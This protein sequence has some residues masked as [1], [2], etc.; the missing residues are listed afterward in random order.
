MNRASTTIDFN[1]DIREEHQSLESRYEIIKTLGSGAFGQVYKVRNKTATHNP[2]R[3]LKEIP[4]ATSSDKNTKL[5][6]IIQE[7]TSLVQLQCSSDINNNNDFFQECSIVEVYDYFSMD[8]QM[9]FYIEMEYISGGNLNS[10][11]QNLIDHKSEKQALQRI[12]HNFITLISTLQNVHAHCILHR[13][14]KPENILY[15]A[16]HDQ[17]VLGDF[18]SSCSQENCFGVT[19]T[20]LF[21][22]PI[23]LFKTRTVDEASDIYSLGVCFYELITQ[24]KYLSH[25]IDEQQYNQHYLEAIKQLQQVQN[26][27]FRAR[28]DAIENILD[29]T[30]A[31]FDGNIIIPVPQIENQILVMIEAVIKMIDPFN[32]KNRPSLDSILFYLTSNNLDNIINDSINNSN[33]MHIDIQPIK[34]Y[35]CPNLQE[36]LRNVEMNHKLLLQLQALIVQ[37]IKNNT[38]PLSDK[39]LFIRE[40][41]KLMK[42]NKSIN[43]YK[44]LLILLQ[45]HQ[46]QLWQQYKHLILV[47]SING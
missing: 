20:T 18:G 26:R 46:D 24:E 17:L 6:N 44:I 45:Q 22:D 12:L 40:L 27:V 14:I 34:I 33:T 41:K 42:L 13:D 23:A 1:L 31:P 3:A 25:F 30:D 21:I 29:Y 28:Q 2:I 39:T 15:D 37:L 10:F 32:I 43:Q 36:P 9:V 8:Q 4:I 11:R 47:N 7:I 5:L 38:K 16:Q 19:G 35:T